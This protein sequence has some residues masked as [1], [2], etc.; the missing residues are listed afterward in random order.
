[1][2]DQFWAQ[3]ADNLET[4][5]ALAQLRA[6]FIRRRTLRTAVGYRLNRL[7]D[8]A[9]D[10]QRIADFLEADRQQVGWYW[11]WPGWA[12]WAPV[13]REDWRDWFDR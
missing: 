8:I 3:L 12:D 6:E 1:M 7:W 9:A 2:E 10:I 5:K 13:W 4:E 11:V